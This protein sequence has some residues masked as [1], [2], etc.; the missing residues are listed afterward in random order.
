[1]KRS[2]II[3]AGLLLCVGVCFAQDDVA[4]GSKFLTI[5]DISKIDAKNKTMTISYATSYD[6]GQLRSAG[7]EGATPGGRAGGRGSGGGVGVRGGGGRRGG[8]GGGV[9]ASGRTASAPIPMDYKVTVSSKTVLKEGE[10][11][12]NLDDF[13]VGDHVQVFS[14]K[15][16]TKIEASEVIRTPK[17]DH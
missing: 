14:L 3:A 1:M 16:G 8:G 7:V 2:I 17:E 5:G 12:L 11:P 6:I 13:K 4:S 15:G 9:P 10:G